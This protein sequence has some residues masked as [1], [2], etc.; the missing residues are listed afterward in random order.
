VSPLQDGRLAIDAVD[1]QIIAL[2]A[3]RRRIVALV[4]KS[5]QS[6]GLPAVDLER[7]HALQ[8]HWRKA[9]EEHAVPTEV[10]LAVLGA[11]LAPSRAHVQSIF[12][13]DGGPTKG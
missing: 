8:E 2:L 1:R 12:E 13:G 3:E 6:L 9:A 4:A 5:K 10:A 7:E 11:L